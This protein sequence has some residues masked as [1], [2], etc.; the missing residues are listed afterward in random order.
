MLYEV[1]TRNLKQVMQENSYDVIHVHDLPLV[2]VA[3]RA[4]KRY[5]VK[6]VADY[7]ENRPEIMKY[8]LV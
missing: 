6:V 1:I 5:G 3:L 8:Y 7:H 2:E 4:Q